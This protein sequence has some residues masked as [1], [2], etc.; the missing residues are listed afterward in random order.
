MS[1]LSS[2]LAS[3][4]IPALESALVA[5]EPDVQVAVLGEIE[6]LSAQVGEWITTKLASHAPADKQ[7]L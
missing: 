2:F 4:L 7:G 1:L 3:H 5:H 6:A